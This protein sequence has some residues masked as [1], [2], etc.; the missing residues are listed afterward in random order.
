MKVGN[1]SIYGS[2]DVGQL[3]QVVEEKTLDPL[4]N[5]EREAHYARAI[6]KP[7]FR[8]W[9]S[10]ASIVLGR[11][12][13]P[14][15]E[16]DLDR[17]GGLGIPVLHRSSGGGAVYHDRGNVNYSIYI[18]RMSA[19][20]SRIGESLMELSFPVIEVLESLGIRWSW[21]P[22]NN[23]Y[24][25]GRKIS[26]SAQARSGVRMLHHGTFLVDADLDMMS[27][28]LLAGGRSDLAPVVNLSDMISGITAEAVEEM[29][30]SALE[31]TP[32]VRSYAQN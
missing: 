4:T 9:R 30:T 22:P 32:L 27:G 5:L 17:A 31:G 1:A 12:Q 8:V 10:E 26:G 29:L 18:P 6:Q 11:F 2:T 7:S 16:V 13:T 21:V 3:C 25:L 15:E 14:E 28:L 20:E 23:V 24:A 19:R